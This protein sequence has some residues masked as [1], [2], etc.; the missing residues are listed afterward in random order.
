MSSD[1]MPELSHYDVAM[2]DVEIDAMQY[3]RTPGGEFEQRMKRLGC[4][5]VTTGE[6]REPLI[7]RIVSALYKDQ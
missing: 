3:G 6:Q 7:R 4:N 2:L 5:V 1:S